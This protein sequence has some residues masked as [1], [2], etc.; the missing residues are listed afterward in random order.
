[1]SCDWCKKPI[2]DGARVCSECGRRQGTMGLIASVSTLVGVVV[3]LLG[4]MLSSYQAAQT[5]IDSKDVTVALEKAQKASADS[6]YALNEA[7]TAAKSAQSAEQ[8][9]VAITKDLVSL[10]TMTLFDRYDAVMAN[11]QQC[12]PEKSCPEL[13]QLVRQLGRYYK[14]VISQNQPYLSN[15]E[16]TTLDNLWCGNV[17]RIFYY[18]KPRSSFD[19]LADEFIAHC[20]DSHSKSV[21]DVKIMMEYSE[22]GGN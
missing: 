22:S 5:T 11:R 18:Y 10:H 3:A 9:I 16:K 13:K 4:A 21:T 19:A 20:E 8:N 17:A 7:L 2:E 15:E 6:A 14:Y 1:M 12:P